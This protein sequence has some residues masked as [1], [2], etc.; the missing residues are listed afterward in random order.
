MAND[1]SK[2]ILSSHNVPFNQWIWNLLQDNF[3]D[4]CLY[5]IRT[6]GDTLLLPPDDWSD[7]EF[8]IDYCLWLLCENLRDFGMDFAGSRIRG[9]RHRWVNRR[10]NVLISEAQNFDREVEAELNQRSVSQ[11]SMGQHAAYD[12]IIDT[13]DNNRRPN[14]FFLHGPAGT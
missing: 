9:S 10:V 7:E 4:D 8:R 1:Q 11:L 14:P 13:I 12:I 3:T 5:R 2:I 6:T